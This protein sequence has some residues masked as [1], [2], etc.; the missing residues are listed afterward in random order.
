[1]ENSEVCAVLALHL[2][3]TTLLFD[4]TMFKQNDMICPCAMSYW[5]RESSSTWGHPSTWAVITF[6]RC[7]DDR[8]VFCSST[9]AIP[10][11]QILQNGGFGLGVQSA[12]WVI[13]EK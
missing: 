11:E 13:E 2:G 8:Q 1:M 4:F 3:P 9:K 5:R 10:T 7:H 6:V 12:E